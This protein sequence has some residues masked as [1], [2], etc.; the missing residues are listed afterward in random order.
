VS[1][2]SHGVLR[3]SHSFNS[4][5]VLFAV[6]GVQALYHKSRYRDP[7]FQSIA[8]YHLSIPRLILEYANGHRSFVSLLLVSRL[9]S[10]SRRKMALS[11]PPFLEAITLSQF[12]SNFKTLLRLAMISLRVLWRLVRSRFFITQRSLSPMSSPPS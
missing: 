6:D 4:H 8:S 12:L 3:V 1:L 11:F 10:M 7:H 9:R 5:P 2:C